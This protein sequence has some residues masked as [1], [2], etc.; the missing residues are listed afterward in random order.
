MLNSSSTFLFSCSPSETCSDLECSF[1]NVFV[2][3][4]KE[5][6]SFMDETKLLSDLPGIPSSVLFLFLKL[7]RR[8]EDLLLFLGFF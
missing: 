5:L 7:L 4:S 2:F 6:I 8:L 1:R 3:D